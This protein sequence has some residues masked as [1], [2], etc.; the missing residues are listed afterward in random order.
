LAIK[1]IDLFFSVKSTLKYYYQLFSKMSILT[2]QLIMNEIR[3]PMD[4]INIIKEY[5][6]YNIVEET[7][8]KKEKVCR[9]IVS[10]EFSRANRFN[11]DPTYSDNDESWM[12]GYDYETNAY[13]EEIQLQAT[14]CSTCGN[15]IHY[16]H[17]YTINSII[18][19]CGDQHNDDDNDGWNTDDLYSDDEEEDEEEEEQR[20]WD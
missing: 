11:S 17:D 6:F 18:C 5:S 19:H 7:K 14:I 4:M 3:L 12:F 16:C 1:K 20:F 8:K 13:G 10:A 9:A 15:Y 2:K